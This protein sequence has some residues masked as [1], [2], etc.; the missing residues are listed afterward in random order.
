MKYSIKKN[1]IT[2]TTLSGLGNSKA[3][4]SISFW[5][6]AIPILA[7]LTEKFPSEINLGIFQTPILL[8]WDIPFS[9]KVL[10]GAT[11]LFTTANI[12][13][14]LYAPK[15]IKDY[16]T[17]AEFKE[18]EGSFESLKQMFE[19]LLERSSADYQDTLIKDFFGH[20]ASNEAEKSYIS[21]LR[22]RF[23][24]CT[25]STEHH[26]DAFSNIK[27][28]FNVER[29]TIT[30]IIMTFYAFG[31]ICLAFLLIQNIQ[32]VYFG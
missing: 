22:N 14:S 8:N 16:K 24:A 20:V 28:A 27:G 7:K 31:F 23:D 10:Y 6:I 18:K 30:K 32:Y 3:I 25:V 12:L 4:K 19:E 15:I 29:P 2:W 21:N 1:P 13:Y 17:F 26:A 5:F 11:L 9:L